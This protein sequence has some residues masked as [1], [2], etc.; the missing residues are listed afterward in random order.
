MFEKLQIQYA[1]IGVAGVSVD[2]LTSIAEQALGVRP[3]PSRAVL[4]FWF[5]VTDATKWWKEGEAN[6][7]AVGADRSGRGAVPP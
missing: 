2:R 6:I 1:R 7:G 4:G 3:D 5:R